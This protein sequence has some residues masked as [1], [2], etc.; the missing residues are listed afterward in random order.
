[1]VCSCGVKKPQ[2]RTEEWRGKRG[3]ATSLP[4]RRR[5]QHTRSQFTGSSMGLYQ[6]SVPRPVLRDI[7][8]P[9]Q[10]GDWVRRQHARCP[11]GYSVGATGLRT[12]KG[13]RGFTVW[14]GEGM[15][16]IKRSRH[17]G[18]WCEA[19]GVMVVWDGRVWVGDHGQVWWDARWTN[20]WGLITPTH[21]V[22][23]ERTAVWCGHMWWYGQGVAWGRV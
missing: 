12:V 15:T 7:R 2:Q 6:A 22:R 18:R 23:R 16:G 13:G 5:H 4:A 19:C 9:G 17:E 8:E 10:G 14:F 11:G 1:M 20:G 21:H 3:I